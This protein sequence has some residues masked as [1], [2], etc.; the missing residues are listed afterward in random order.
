MTQHQQYMNDFMKVFESLTRWGPGSESETTKA[1]SHVPISPK[2]VLEIGCG[3][4]LATLV[5]A[6]NLTAHITS[7][8]NEQ[9][10]LDGLGSVLKDEHLEDRVDLKCASMTELPYEAESFDLIWSEASAYIMGVENALLSWKP[11]LKANGILVFSDLI[12]L[13][14]EPSEEVKTFWDKEYP[15]IQ[16]AETRR[17][18]IIDAGYEILADFTFNQSSWDNYYSP[19][20]KRVEEL[21]PSMEASAALK[22]IA[23]E[24]EFYLKNNSEY[25]YQMFILKNNG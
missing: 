15:D 17:K 12:L 21:L 8:D 25:G 13:T 4:G 9:S 1:L 2:S 23:S 16:T 24:V 5:L 10:A 19:L 7:V 14:P 18:Q 6:K 3:K 11:L 20:K 22:D